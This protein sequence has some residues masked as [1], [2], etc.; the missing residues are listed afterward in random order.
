[1]S[2]QQQQK[3]IFGNAFIEV[4]N[5][6]CGL[7]TKNIHEAH[8][9]FLLRQNGV[10]FDIWRDMAIIMKLT[11]QNVH[12]FY[13]N[14][15]S[16]IFSDDIAPYRKQIKQMLM[17]QQSGSVQQLVKNIISQLK[18]NNPKLNLHYQTIY[19]FINYQIKRN[20]SNQQCTN[21]NQSDQINAQF[22]ELTFSVF[23]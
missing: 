11:R 2:K 1:M 5:N 7:N 14:T 10:T 15:W 18:Y 19:Q 9:Q 13:H 23:D 3:I 16:K 12:D 21:V 8:E 22:E 4:I 17:Y 6:K 20:S